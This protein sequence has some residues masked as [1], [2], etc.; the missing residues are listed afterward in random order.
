[1]ALCASTCQAPQKALFGMEVAQC[2]LLVVF[3][4]CFLCAFFADFFHGA[5]GAA[6]AARRA[7]RNR[8]SAAAAEAAG[9]ARQAKM[10]V[11]PLREA[12]YCKLVY[13]FFRDV[14]LFMYC[15]V[16]KNHSEN[17]RK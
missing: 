9:A 17:S 14:V 13:F 10:E 12:S 6:G 5:R 8:R 2:S 7:R 16:R 1:M 3:V 11:A 15:I 4:A